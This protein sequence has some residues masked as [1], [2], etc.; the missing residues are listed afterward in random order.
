VN[1]AL[2]LGVGEGRIYLGTPTKTRLVSVAK[3][4]F[5]AQDHD[6]PAEMVTGFG[7]RWLQDTVCRPFSPTVAD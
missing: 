5:A 6:F 2:I 4:Y 3:L 1:R 7:E